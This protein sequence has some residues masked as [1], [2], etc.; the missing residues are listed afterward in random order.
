M[1]QHILLMAFIAIAMSSCGPIIEET[2][3]IRKDIVETVFTSGELVAEGTYDLTA[4]GDG[5]LLE[6]NFEEGD[7]VQQ[8][9]RLALIQNETPRLNT[10]SSKALLDI[11][12]TN[13]SPSGPALAQA[14]TSIDIARKQVAQDSIQAERYHRLWQQNS[15]AKIDYETAQLSL[16]T[17]KS[18]LEAAIESYQK[19][20]S[21][22]EQQVINSANN[23]QLNLEQLRDIEIIAIQPGKVYK[24]HK[25]AGDY[26]RKGEVI[27]TIADAEAIYAE[28]FIDENSIAKIEKTQKAIV[29]LNTNPDKQYQAVV[30]AILPAFDDVNQSFTCHLRFVD[31]LDFKIVGTQLQA[32]IVVDSTSNALLIP[33]EYLDYNGYV[34]VKGQSEK[35]KV[36]SQTVSNQWVHVISGIPDT[37]TLTV[38]LN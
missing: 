32:N 7:L 17:S 30:D 9:Q 4:K 22:A 35:V 3:P 21:D 18:N 8:N 10:S 11:S 38:R 1:K 26:V 27:A 31:P 34:T 19:I 33:R 5:Y 15:I 16:S 24:K 36:E 12:R 37:V 29:Q 13:A 25:S 6:V 20:R 2:Q 14:Q 23:Y 28:V